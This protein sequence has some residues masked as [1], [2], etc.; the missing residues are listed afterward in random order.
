MPPVAEAVPEPVAEGY[1]DLLAFDVGVR[2]EIE[3]YAAEFEALRKVKIDRGR[4][5]GVRIQKERAEILFFPAVLDGVLQ[6]IKRQPL[7]I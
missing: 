4:V 3:V 1:P 2:I 5:A 6:Y 7:A